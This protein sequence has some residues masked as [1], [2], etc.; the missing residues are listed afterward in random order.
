MT[1]TYKVR[2]Y[3]LSAT[4]PKLY[5]RSKL[6]SRGEAIKADSHVPSTDTNTT[7]D[8]W[9]YLRK[10]II[11]LVITSYSYGCKI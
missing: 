8:Q 10:N 7:S 4:L 1:R 5:L 3:F 9:S 11:I 6:T 2:S